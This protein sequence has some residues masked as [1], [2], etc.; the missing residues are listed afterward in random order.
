MVPPDG[1]AWYRE[2]SVSLDAALRAAALAREAMRVVKTERLDRGLAIDR[3][4]DPSGSGLIGWRHSAVTSNAG[5]LSAKQTSVN[6]NFAAL[7]VEMLQQAGVRPQH[8]VAVGLSGS[9]PALNICVYA[10]LEVLGVNAL[11]ICGAAAS[12]W[13]ANHPEWLWLDMQQA[14]HAC[15]L[16]RIRPLAASLGGRADRAL[17][18]PQHGRHRL[19]ARVR[20]ARLPLL[21]AE[22]QRISVQ[23][24]MQIYRRAAAGRRIA[25]YINVGGQAASVGTQESKHGFRPGLNLRALG[26][27]PLPC[28]IGEFL[29]L[30]VPVLHFVNIEQLARR[31]GFPRCPSRIPNAIQP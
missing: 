14:L 27:P 28:V 31:Y 2:R 10:A 22:T 6:P 12:Q 9:F 17:D 21:S 30:G 13:G 4:L 5:R 15:G 3:T 18:L 7:V 23:Q 1:M 16:L 29:A 25:A 11:C 26:T 20:A 19:L 24:R 8:C